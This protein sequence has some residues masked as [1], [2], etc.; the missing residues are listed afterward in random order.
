MRDWKE[1]RLWRW[2]KAAK[3]PEAV[4]VKGLL[5]IRMPEIQ[6]ILTSAGTAPTDFTL[7][8]GEHSF[9]VAE[10]MCQIIPI[11]TQ[12]ALSVYE[13]ALLLFSAYLHD[14]GM[15]PEQEKLRRHWRHLLF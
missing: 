6:Q 4:R 8:D 5:A 1:T 9:R 3:G 14:I 10:R 2:I 7:H 12:S 15:T 13:L 11:D